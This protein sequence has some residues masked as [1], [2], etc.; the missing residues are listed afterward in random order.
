VITFILAP[1]SQVVLLGMISAVARKAINPLAVG[2]ILAEERH[3]YCPTSQRSSSEAKV[4]S[5]AILQLRPAQVARS[6]EAI[7][8]MELILAAVK[9]TERIFKLLE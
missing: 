6:G 3:S 4:H 2:N 5:D 1:I 7:S 9:E 8:N